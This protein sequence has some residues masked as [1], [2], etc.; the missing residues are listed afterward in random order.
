MAL[1]LHFKFNFLG[2][3]VGK[4]PRHLLEG[5]HP[6][7]PLIQPQTLHKVTHGQYLALGVSEQL[8]V[9]FHLSFLGNST[10]VSFLGD[11]ML[12][13]VFRVWRQNKDGFL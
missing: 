2:F 5:I 12:A 11:S 3:R 13:S 6:K 4:I 7:L 8:K 10:L 9:S 1:S